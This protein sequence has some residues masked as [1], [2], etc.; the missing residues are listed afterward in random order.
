MKRTIQQIIAIA[1]ATV[2]ESVQQPIAFLILAA[3]VLSTLL[4]PVFQ[5]HR[6]S[7]DGRLARDSGLSCML[8]FGLVLAVTTAGSAVA[9]EIT[10]GTAAAIIGKPVSRVTFVVSKWLGIC[11]VLLIFWLGICA[12][13]LLAER[14]SY[15]F[16]MPDEC[17]HEDPGVTCACCESPG[18]QMDTVTLTLGICG[19]GAA[20]LLA[21]LRHYFKRRRFGVS[22]FVGVAVSQ[23][24][25]AG[26]CGFYSRFGNLRMMRP[27][28][29]AYL[30]DLDWRILPAALLVLFALMLFA[31]L[32]TALATRLPTGPVL[33]VC[34]LALVLG[35]AGDSFAAGAGL[36][37]WRGLL[38]GLVPDIQ[39][40]WM[41]DALA[42]GGRIAWPYVA[43]AAVYALSCCAL[44]LT[45]GC[46]A[47]RLRDLG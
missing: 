35:L 36:A 17:A 29:A 31:A 23:L 37:S 7:E 42:H 40:F 30:P 33:A 46:L 10:R 4:V 18:H 16:V 32:A 5:F 24:C 14:G 22:A 28:T 38:A 21:A 41:C 3:G 44:F 27:D 34:V 45:A 43:E 1:K 8:V 26:L 9:A 2:L 25:V 12:A 39:H 15:H 19:V 13:T 20:M 11:G 6:F 47:F